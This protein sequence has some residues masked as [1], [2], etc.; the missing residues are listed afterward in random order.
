[1][2]LDVISIL[3]KILIFLLK[4]NLYISLVC[5][6][7]TNC[8]LY[9]YAENK[10][11]KEGYTIPK[12]ESIL[13]VFLNLVIRGFIFFIPIINLTTTINYL[14]NFDWFYKELKAIYSDKHIDNSKII[15]DENEKEDTKDV[16]NKNIEII[17]IPDL[18]IDESEFDKMS[19]K[20]QLEFLKKYLND[21]REI[22]ES[23]LLIDNNEKKEEGKKLI[24]KKKK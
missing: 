9:P 13:I 6:I 15:A 2:L 16:E 10:L 17:K 23:E 5:N 14:F 7:I 1:M 24:N 19:E 3:L 11:E 22:I 8:I 18:N 21:N 4:A 20:E 12:N